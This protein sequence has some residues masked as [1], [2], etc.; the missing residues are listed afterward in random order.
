MRWGIGPRLA[1]LGAFNAAVYL[2]YVCTGRHTLVS[3]GVSYSHLEL[4]AYWNKPPQPRC[5]S[6]ATGS[7]ACVLAS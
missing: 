2:A 7:S 1:A 5:N 4:E 3:A 6:A